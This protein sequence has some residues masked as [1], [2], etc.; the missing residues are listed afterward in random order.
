MLISFWSTDRFLQI[1]ILGHLPQSLRPMAETRLSSLGITAAGKIDRC[2]AIADKL[3]P[4]LRTYDR[5]GNRIDEIEFHPAYIEMAIAG[6]EAGL[7]WLHYDP[8]MRREYGYIPYLLTIGG[9]GYLFAQAESGLFCPIC[10]TDGVARVIEKFGDDYL[11]QHVLPRLI[12]RSFENLY[13]GAMFLT[14]KQGGSDVGANTCRATKDTSG[15]WRLHGEKWFCSNAGAEAI[16]VLARPDGAPSGTRGLGLFYMPKYLDDGTRNSYRINRLKDKLGVRSM[17]TGEIT[18]NGALAYPVGRLDRG[19]VQMAEMINLSRL[20]NAVASVAIMRRATVEALIHSSGRHAFG[21]RIIDLPLTTRV[22]ADL[23][24]EQR[25]CLLLVLET[26]RLLDKVESGSGTSS[27]AAQVRLLT[28]LV[29][30]YTARMAV[31][32]ASEAMEVLGGNGYIEEFVT[33]RL[34]RDAQVLPIWEG[35]TNIL[36]LDALRAARKESAHLALFDALAAKVKDKSET[37]EKALIELTREFEL[38]LEENPEREFTAKML[39]DRLCRLIQ[40]VFLI[41]ETNAP[42]ASLV[43]ECYIDKHLGDGINLANARKLVL[44]ELESLNME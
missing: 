41:S 36:V 28:P 4:V 44:G 31:W 26:I 34:L 16:L 7:V 15:W 9:M 10:M 35:T 43:A 11:K 37:V 40:A 17:P 12:S 39:T 2:A 33:A 42:D 32:A 24:L 3:T 8:E 14:E 13:Q 6:Y 22:L 21:K 19:F 25:A 20:Y 38:L 5:Y 23:I 1:Y 30:Y 29:K 27:E 18:L